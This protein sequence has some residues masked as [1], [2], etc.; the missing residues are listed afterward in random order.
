MTARKTKR[1][2]S[3]K[4]MLTAVD[5]YSGCGAVS[6]GLKKGGFRVVAAIDNDPIAC[7]T[8]RL[9]HPDVE[10]FER[11][12]RLVKPEEIKKL[13]GRKK[14]GLLVLC[15]PCQPYSSQNRK[16]RLDARAKLILQ[17]V[18]FAKVLKPRAIFFENVPGITSK[19][20][21]HI[22]EE[23]R[24]GLNAAGYRLSD[25]VNLD[26]ASFGVPQRRRR[27]ILVATYKTDPPPIPETASKR[28]KRRTVRDAIGWLP[29]LQS[30]K[31][32]LRDPLHFARQHSPIALERLAHIPKNG[33]SRSALPRKLRLGCHD[34][35]RGH[36]DV[37]GR[38]HWN[39]AAPT[40]TTGCTDITKGR[41]AHPRD[42]RGITLREAA[43][44]Q[45]FPRKYRFSGNTFEMARQIGNA[46]PVQLVRA[47][48]PMLATAIRKS[49]G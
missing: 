25:P 40:L 12:V 19:R 35:R 3:R 38:M 23:L 6:A 22:L 34:G 11:D 2:R 8:Y 49:G 24:N 32:W 4:Q 48:A 18:R 30:G 15:A 39:K 33:G 28:V 42:D 9:N 37:Y 13:L 14:L 31:A 10:M 41:Y 1:Q 7:T 5:I 20:A 36:E 21:A 26:A 43:C 44:L 29:S 45:T 16:K 27:C 47:L 17:A 46:V